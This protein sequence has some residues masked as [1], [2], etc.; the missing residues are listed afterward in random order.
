MSDNGLMQTIKDRLGALE[1]SQAKLSQEIASIRDREDRAKHTTDPHTHPELEEAV[2]A[3]QEDTRALW[4]ALS[5]ATQEIEKRVTDVARSLKDSFSDMEEFLDGLREG[6]PGWAQHIQDNVQRLRNI[7]S[8]LAK[9][10]F[11]EGKIT[12]REASG[13]S[14]L[15]PRLFQKRNGSGS[16]DPAGEDRETSGRRPERPGGAGPRRGHT[17]PRA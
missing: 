10:A 7:V 17:P 14:N 1:G 9:Q 3:L 13:G 6:F 16:R 15:D 2:H 5:K 12:S 11:D 8:V 4:A